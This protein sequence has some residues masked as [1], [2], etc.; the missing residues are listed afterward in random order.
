MKI[1]W[2]SNS[3]NHHRYGYSTL[4][5]AITEGLIKFGHKIVYFGM[6][7]VENPY[8]DEKGRLMIG[9]KANTYA[10]D[11]I[12]DII[13]VFNP[14]LI[15]SALDLFPIGG[16]E[17][18]NLIEKTGKPWIHHVTINTEPLFLPLVHGFNKPQA[19]IAPCRENLRILTEYNN[20]IYLNKSLL[21]THGVD[22]TIFNDD[23][24]N[25]IKKEIRQKFNLSENCFVVIS[26][27]RNNSV[28]SKGQEQLFE[29]WKKFVEKNNLAP[30]QAKLLVLSDPADLGGTNLIALRDVISMTN[31]INFV[32]FKESS[33]GIEPTFENDKK[34]S[35]HFFTY[36]FNP[37]E[38]SKLYKMA[39]LHLT[40]SLG[41]SFCLPMLEAAACGI[42]SI[43]SDFIGTKNLMDDLLL[44]D[45]KINKGTIITLTF[46]SKQF[47]HDTDAVA[48]K[49][50]EF[51]KL[52]ENKKE[53]LSKM[54]SA[55]ACGLY[56]WDL[57]I[58]Q[59]INLIN[60]FENII[61]QKKLDFNN[62]SL[63]L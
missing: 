53:E 31:Y 17:L 45:F 14:D 44:Q 27:F 16:A 38:M 60:Q 54:V 42:P 47:F 50:T 59:W 1:L 11:I 62:R 4:S 46:Y 9:L 24:K 21:I 49:I 28:I 58:P 35:P 30:E 5:E 7:S 33:K 36:T 61:K 12:T 56:S 26:V 34:G 23:D 22:T 63:G 52:D 3:I 39:D 8:Y 32:W 41:E 43:A 57:I 18:A 37:E 55:R 10:T 15:I 20:G 51:Y 40:T 13:K 48:E 2:F 25:K 29:S 19:L 6:Q